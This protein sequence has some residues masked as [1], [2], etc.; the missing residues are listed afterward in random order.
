MRLSNELDSSN[1]R[2]IREKLMERKYDTSVDGSNMYG[3]SKRCRFWRVE[4]KDSQDTGML[5]AS[6]RSAK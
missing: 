3:K 5:T 6:R 1:D 4:V 2:L